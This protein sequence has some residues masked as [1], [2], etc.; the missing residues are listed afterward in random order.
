MMEKIK[1]LSKKQLAIAVVTSIV[2][3]VLLVLYLFKSPEK[4]QTNE[5]TS[6]AQT[7]QTNS[8]K[9]KESETN[10]EYFADVK[11]EVH[12]P[13][14]YPFEEGDRVGKLIESAG[15]LT[16]NADANQVNLAA[17]AEDAM[18]IYVPAKGVVESGGDT[19]ASPAGG[20][21]DPNSTDSGNA[22]V[23]GATQDHNGSVATGG[24][25]PDESK[26]N[27]NTATKEELEAVNGIGPSL[28]GA[29][30]QYRSDNGRF[31]QMEDLKEVPG[32]GD[33]TY[34]K[35]KDFFYVA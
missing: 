9:E 22:A 17:L 25:A 12:N 35:L 4:E 18:V 26:V 34:E 24:S 21:V 2:V 31:N 19:A 6:T 33:K 32:I 10:K 3:I 23:N 11:G 1:N 5:W 7:A 13:G 16:E 28:A 14:V 27:L 8:A 29:I 15:G 20:A 30:L